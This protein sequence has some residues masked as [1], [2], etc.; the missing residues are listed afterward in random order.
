MV[1]D[2]CA[3]A[4]AALV[5][6]K[7]RGRDFIFSST[8]FNIDV[9]I[10]ACSLRYNGGYRCYGMLRKRSMMRNQIERIRVMRVPDAKD[11]N[12]PKKRLQISSRN[13]QSGARN[14]FCRTKYSYFRYFKLS[15]A[16]GLSSLFP[17]LSH[18]LIRYDKIFCVHSG[19][20]S[21]AISFHIPSAL[22]AIS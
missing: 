12:I 2:T 5:P 18:P 20:V 16:R 8:S 9:F 10:L 17:R 13:H 22:G 21:A 7:V 4:I 6:T 11:A 15:A 1:L 19:T 14:A 3:I